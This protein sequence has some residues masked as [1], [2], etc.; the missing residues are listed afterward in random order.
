VNRQ[1][2]AKILHTKKEAKQRNHTRKSVE[3]YRTDRSEEK[4]VHKQKKTIFIERGLEELERL[5]SNSEN[6]SFYQ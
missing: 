1:Q 6:K 2:V 5:R 3:E 4:K